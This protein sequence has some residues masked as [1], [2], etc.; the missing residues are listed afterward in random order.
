[1]YQ[2]IVLDTFGTAE[3]YACLVTEG[4][5]VLSLFYNSFMEFFGAEI[6]DAI[7][8]RNEATLCC[9]DCVSILD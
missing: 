2:G 7:S 5:A 6:N 1:M 9:S 4:M 8:L 3:E